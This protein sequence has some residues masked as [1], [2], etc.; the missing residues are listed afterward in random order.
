MI[1]AGALIHYH[2]LPAALAALLCGEIGFSRVLEDEVGV[3]LEN[4]SLR[5]R[6]CQGEA[7]GP[8]RLELQ[9]RELAAE[10]A[11]LVAAGDWREQ[12]RSDYLSVRWQ[13]QRLSHPLGVELQLLRHFSED[14]LG[15]LPPLPCSL[16]WQ[17]EAARLL[18]QLLTLVP[19]EFRDISRQRATARAEYLAVAAGGLC[20][21]T[22]H[23]LQGLVD[24]TPAFQHALLAERIRAAGHDP[25][26]LF[27]ARRPC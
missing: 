2:P 18:Q 13:R 24:I 17:P 21:S 8:L 26:P 9:L 27:A 11:A 4:G 25:E 10:V 5:L 23:A 7:T 6:L 1:H 14:E 20:T 22:D 16:E 12:G 15:E 3:L 19:L